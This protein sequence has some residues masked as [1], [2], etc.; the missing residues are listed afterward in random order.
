MGKVRFYSYGGILLSS[1]DSCDPSTVAILRMDPRA[2]AIGHRR[3]DN[4]C[5]T[6]L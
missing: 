5:Q 2:G 6:L 4:G 1:P 3:L